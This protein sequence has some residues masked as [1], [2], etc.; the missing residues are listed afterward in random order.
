MMR[1]DQ[2]IRHMLRVPVDWRWVIA[3]AV[4]WIGGTVL[5]VAQGKWL[6]AVVVFVV[7]GWLFFV[8]GAFGLLTWRRQR[9]DS[10]GAHEAG[11]Y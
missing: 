1:R 11:L 8:L 7:L 5:S 10:R 4:P 6:Q 2:R 3:R 9:R